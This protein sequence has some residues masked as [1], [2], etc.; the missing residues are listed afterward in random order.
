MQIVRTLNEIVKNPNSMVTVGTFDGVHLAHQKIL[1]EVTARA[2]A[3]S[4]RSVVITFEPHPKEIVGKDP[5]QIKILTTVDERIE[6]LQQFP[7][8]ILFI[9][10]FTYEFSRQSSRE[11]YQNYVVQ[12]I[13]VSEVV[14]GYDHMFGRDREAGI[15]E[16]KQMGKEF[17]FTVYAMEPVKVN[18]EVVSSTKVRQSLLEGDVEKA[19][20]FL[21]KPY[22]FSGTVIKGDGRGKALGFP[23]ANIKP[24]SEKKCIPKNGVYFVKTTIEGQELLGMMNI[25]VRPTF[26]TDHQQT[27]EVHLFEFDREIYGTTVKIQFLN[28]IRNEVKF[29]SKEELIAQLHRDREECFK[30]KGNLIH[31]NP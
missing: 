24:Q 22:A 23:T 30:L 19:A 1:H 27:L 14:E 4:R 26:R 10:N 13:G 12:K 11:F 9:I 5:G 17:G 28:R 25:G 20:I 8:D 7:I 21:G 15:E 16:L 6:L 3:H 29:Y 31:V 2:N 18:G